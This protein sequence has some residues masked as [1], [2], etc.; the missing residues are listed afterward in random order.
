ML[1]RVPRLLHQSGAGQ[2]EPCRA[3]RRGPRGRHLAR[4][5][6]RLLWLD[7]DEGARPGRVR[8][9]GHSEALGHERR[10][11]VERPARAG[12]PRDGR[13]GIRGVG[14]RFARPGEGLAGAGNPLQRHKGSEDVQAA[15]PGD[16]VQVRR[17]QKG[18]VLRPFRGLGARGPLRLKLRPPVPGQ[19]GSGAR[20][21]RDRDVAHETYRSAT[22]QRQAQPRAG[23][24]QGGLNTWQPLGART[25]RRPAR[26]WPRGVSSPPGQRGPAGGGRRW[27]SSPLSRR[28]EEKR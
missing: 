6:R 7:S 8:S 26:D 28:V 15:L 3:G 5:G 16:I 19:M 23:P 25:A 1:A 2:E 21:A 27:A 11:R 12:A 18:R 13:G 17:D 9:G 22:Q 24:W 10:R 4:D 20:G 14:V